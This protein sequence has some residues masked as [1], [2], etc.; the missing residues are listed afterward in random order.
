MKKLFRWFFILLSTYIISDFLYETIGIRL[1]EV[2]GILQHIDS[3]KLSALEN[4]LE[5]F[6][7]LQKVVYGRFMG[8]IPLLIV[9]YLLIAGI[10]KY[11]KN[12]QKHYE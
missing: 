2:M 6:G 10:E 12:L 9:S 8:D 3:M 5:P 7:G 4:F 11:Y 1:M